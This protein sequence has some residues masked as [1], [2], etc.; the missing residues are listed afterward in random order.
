MIDR[1]PY[2][3]AARVYLAQAR[4]FRLRGSPFCLVLIEWAGNARRRAAACRP[5]PAGQLELF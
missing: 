5:E 3:H 4:H 1:A 2:I